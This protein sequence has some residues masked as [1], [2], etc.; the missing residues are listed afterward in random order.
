MNPGSPAGVSTG[1]GAVALSLK[2]RQRITGNAFSNDML[3]A[4][5]FQWTIPIGIKSTS[6]ISQP[7]PLYAMSPQDCQM[8]LSLLTAPDMFARLSAMVQPDFMPKIPI[9]IRDGHGIIPFQ[10]RAP[11]TVPVK[12]Q[13]SAD[14]KVAC[15]IRDGTHKVRAYDP[16]IWL[17]LL[18]WKSKHRPVIAEFDGPTWKAGDELVALRPL[19]DF[20]PSNAAQY[21]PP[22]L[23]EWAPDN[24]ENIFAI[25]PGTTHF[26][27][28]D[29]SDAYHSMKC[30][31]AAKDMGCSKYKNSQQQDVILEPQ[32][33][34]QGQASSAAYFSPWVR[35]G[36]TRFI[37]QNHLFYWN[38][39][40]DDSCAHGVGEDECLLRYNILGCIKIIMGLRPQLK[41]SPSCTTEKHWAGLVWTVKGICISDTACSAII[42]ACS[43]TPRGTTQMR[44][45]RG[46]IQSGILGFDLSPSH[47]RAFVDLMA[48][49]NEAITTA[50]ASGKYAWP[51]EA[52]E[53]QAQIA[54]KMTNSPKAYTHPDRVL[55]DSHSLLQLG[56]G[57]PF[58]VCAGLISVPV[59]DA[60]DITLDMIHSKAPA[61]CVLVAMYFQTL[62]KHQ[63]K[64]G[65]YE[66]ETFAHVV[67]HRKSHKFVNELMAKFTCIPPTKGSN[68]EVSGGAATAKLKYASDNTTALGTIPTFNIPDGKID[69]LTAKF[70]RFCGWSEEFAV[71]IYWP[72]CYMTVLGDCNSMF[73]TLVRLTAALKA[74]L[75]GIEEDPA[76]VDCSIPCA[77]TLI[78][79]AETVADQ[80]SLLCTSEEPE[81][82]CTE[83]FDSSQMSTFCCSTE[84]LIKTRSTAHGGGMH[85]STLYPGTDCADLSDAPREATGNVGFTAKTLPTDLSIHYLGL[86]QAQWQTLIMMYARDVVSTY[87]GIRIVDIYHTLMSTSAATHEC[88]AKDIATIKAWHD[89]LF[90]L[91]DVGVP[92][93][94][95]LYTPASQARSMERSGDDYTKLLVPVI[96]DL[97]PV[98]LSTRSLTLAPLDENAPKW[99]R[100]LLRED[101]LWIVHYHPTPHATKTDTVNSSMRQAW[102]PTIEACAL[103]VHKHCAVCTQDVDVERNVGIGIRSCQRFVWLVVDDKILPSAVADVTSYVSVLSMVDPASG[104]YVQTTQNHECARSLSHHFLQLNLPLRNTLEAFF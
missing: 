62:N 87:A 46:M 4:V 1:Y 44:R 42:E 91:I 66:I 33:C 52:K 82:D 70:Q 23:I 89:K 39:F 71:T 63:Q 36:Y 81:C 48:P 35:Y 12:L 74:R 94:P 60:A 79:Q 103:Q 80:Q 28:H 64:W 102:W 10:T 55:D 54:L 104:H 58:A 13:A 31:D 65:M 56:D 41:R 32:C 20:R 25:P 29:C 90:Y 24:K 15:M 61:G 96:P 34:Q 73:D 40:S 78:C 85:E 53:A 75:P 16:K 9:F 92:G 100:N 101:I 7:T 3:W 14:Y 11:G 5:M 8:A 6:M 18:F 98:R 26:A 19:V 84:T 43:I 68:G 93:M 21:Y 2:Q 59:A 37:G 67:C 86:N 72:V 99:S 83:C 45:L 57:D 69:H 17:M 49:I 50:E 38:D 77:I 97:V 47:L 22:W 27:D 76:Q 30:S 88:S 51:A 95:A